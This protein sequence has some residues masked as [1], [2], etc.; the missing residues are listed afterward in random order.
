MGLAQGPDKSP[1]YSLNARGVRLVFHDPGPAA[2]QAQKRRDIDKDQGFVLAERG[3]LAVVEARFYRSQ[4]LIGRS[5]PGGKRL[6]QEMERDAVPAQ[7]GAHEPF[8]NLGRTAGICGGAEPRERLPDEVFDDRS[9]DAPE[10]IIILAG[11]GPLLENARDIVPVKSVPS[12]I[13]A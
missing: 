6:A 2:S 10:H 5:Q 12:L 7:I 13:R 4:A 9:R 3:G 1:V 8:A 11:P